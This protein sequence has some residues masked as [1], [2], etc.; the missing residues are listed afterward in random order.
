MWSVISG[1]KDA[2]GIPKFVY[3]GYGL[4]KDKNSN[5][6]KRLGEKKKAQ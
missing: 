1:D 4:Q 3:N 5:A 6:I 2:E